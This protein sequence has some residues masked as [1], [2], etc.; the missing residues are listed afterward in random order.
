MNQEEL[1]VVI[2][3]LARISEED[4]RKLISYLTALRDS[5]YNESPQPSCCRS[6]TSEAL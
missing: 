5:V 6:M 4:K 2:E 1:K 3:L